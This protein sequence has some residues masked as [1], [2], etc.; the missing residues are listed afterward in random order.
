M[1]TLLV[2]RGYN[3]SL[4]SVRSTH[5]PL[6]NRSWDPGNIARQF[7]SQSLTNCHFGVR[8]SI[9]IYERRH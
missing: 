6:N 8:R 2:I 4:L 5:V 9:G 7:L 1:P 3:S